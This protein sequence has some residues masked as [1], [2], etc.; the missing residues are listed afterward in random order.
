MKLIVEAAKRQ[1]QL[2]PIYADAEETYNDLLRS[3]IEADYLEVGKYR[4]QRDIAEQML[5][6][7][8][9]KS[10]EVQLN[11]YYRILSV[12]SSKK[13]GFTVGLR[14]ADDRREFQAVLDDNFVF[15]RDVNLE[16]IKNA[17]WGK[18][19]IHLRINGK[20]LRGAIQQA[21]IIEVITDSIK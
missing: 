3:T 13:E 19:D 6:Q 11:G 16:L 2:A 12:D 20:E 14:S 9:E 21:T 18:T 4:L 15:R 7:K 8:R 17:E 1:P 5:R 10:V